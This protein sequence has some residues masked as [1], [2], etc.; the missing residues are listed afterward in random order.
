MGSAEGARPRTVWTTPRRLDLGH[1]QSRKGR[2]RSPQSETSMRSFG[3]LVGR[4]ELK[5]LLNFFFHLFELDLGLLFESLEHFAMKLRGGALVI[6]RRRGLGEPE[7]LRDE[8]DARPVHGV[9]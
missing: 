9:E 1:L 2:T 3:R 5:P 7:S 4:E 8:L 6:V